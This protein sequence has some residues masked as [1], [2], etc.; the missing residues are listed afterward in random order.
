MCAM[1]DNKKLA[2]AID[3]RAA[4]VGNLC[5]CTG[6]EP[7]I[8]AGSEVDPAQMRPINELYPPVAMLA[9]FGRQRSESV[10]CALPT[11]SG[12]RRWAMPTLLA[13]ACTF[14]RDNPGCTVIAG[15][16]DVGVQI[17]KGMRDP[18]SILSLSALR[19][20]EEIKVENGA[21]VAGALSSIGDL[22][23]I[24]QD[25]LP[26]YAKLLYWFGSPPIKNAA[27]VGGNIANGSPI[28]DSMPAMY[29]LNA[30]IE[31]IGVT[32]TRRVNINDFYTGYRRTVMAADELITRVLIPIPAPDEIFKLYKVSRR[33][34]LDISAF[35]AAIWMQRDGEI[36]HEARIAYG[37]VGP[38]I[39][40]LRKTEAFFAGKA[41]TPETVREAG[42][43]A[44]S[45][46]SPISDVRG[47]AAFRSQLGENILRKFY[48][49]L[50]AANGNG[51]SHAYAV[52]PEL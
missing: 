51:N 12:E 24:S 1:L 7:I 21:I 52:N 44:R 27:T 2:S 22:E 16:T 4:C 19:E 9:E 15:G 29:V 36:V 46:I 40:R 38:N 18:R 17:N 28:G 48:A 23:R 34:D 37:G 20:L 10:G 5:R 35:T 32:T 39:I 31:L 6:Y 47:S 3:V 49:E 33:K 43:I 26:E 13:E 45:E 11:T 42:R 14:K 8:R 41:I 25:A 30:Q 50:S